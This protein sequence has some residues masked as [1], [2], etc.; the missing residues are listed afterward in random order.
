[1]R[2]I[3]VQGCGIGRKDLW[4]IVALAG[5]ALTLSFEAARHGATGR[6]QMICP[7]E[8]AVPARKPYGLNCTFGSAMLVSRAPVAA[9]RRKQRT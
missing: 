9:P 5:R 2:R 4:E 7:I 3:L 1:M 8:K 6:L